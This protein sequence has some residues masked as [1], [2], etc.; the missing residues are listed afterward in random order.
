MICSGTEYQ[1][2]LAGYLKGGRRLCVGIINDHLVVPI[3]PFA[4][5]GAAFFERYAD[6]LLH[7]GA[8]K[9]EK[10][11]LAGDDNRQQTAQQDHLYIRDA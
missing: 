11:C 10:F 9:R 7:G 3:G 8:F 5:M 1:I 6:P 4:A 2:D